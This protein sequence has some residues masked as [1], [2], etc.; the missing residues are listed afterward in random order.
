[1][2]GGAW[3]LGWA[4][5]GVGTRSRGMAWDSWALDGRT[6]DGRTAE[7]G[8]GTRRHGCG[9]LGIE[10]HWTAALVGTRNI[11]LVVRVARVRAN[12]VVV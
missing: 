7:G 10:R 8:T 12:G 5:V 2:G 11:W 3:G 1:M 9:F 4:G 6:A